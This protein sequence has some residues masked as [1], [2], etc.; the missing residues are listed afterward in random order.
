MNDTDRTANRPYMSDGDRPVRRRDIWCYECNSYG[1]VKTE[2]PLAKRRE[3]KCSE[4]SGVGHAKAE[5]P[6]Q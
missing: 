2:C 3:P 6:N 5:C 4:Y 1:H